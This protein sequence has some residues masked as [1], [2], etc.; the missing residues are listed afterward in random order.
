MKKLTAG[1]SFEIPKTLTKSTE[2]KNRERL[3]FKNLSPL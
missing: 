2:K 3:P 1:G